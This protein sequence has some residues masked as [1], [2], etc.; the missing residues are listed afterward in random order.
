[1]NVRLNRYLPAIKFAV[2][3]RPSL[4]IF[5]KVGTSE[6]IKKIFLILE[7]GKERGG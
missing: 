3:E 2:P 7:R 1:M 6:V 4:K 5:K